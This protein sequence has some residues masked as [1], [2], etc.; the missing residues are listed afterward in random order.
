MP[1]G[2]FR[3]DMNGDGELRLG[4]VTAWLLEAFYWPGNWL[5]WAMQ[6]QVPSLG[7]FLEL[8][9][10]DYYG[11]LATALSATVWFALFIAVI[12]TVATVRALDRALT[13]FFVRSYLETRRRFRIGRTLL[14]YR[15]RRLVQRRPA[16]RNDVVVPQVL[17][18]SDQE[19]RALRLHLDLSP[20]FALAVSEV[21]GSLDLGRTETRKLL[22]RLLKLQLLRV[23]LGGSEG[24]SAYTLAPAGRL[25]LSSLTP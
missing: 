5:L 22:D 19:L 4:D 17:E 18:I 8:E 11:V 2:A 23:T 14:G 3:V 13:D 24:E 9:T 6:T 21:A 16:A 1:F 25:F 15:L 10:G 7:R 20:G 12:W